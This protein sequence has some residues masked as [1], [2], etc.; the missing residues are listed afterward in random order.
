MRILVAEDDEPLRDVLVRGLQE[1]GY[2]VDAVADGA[3]AV[4]YAST[5]DYEVVVLDWRMP[6]LDG[7]AALSQLRAR[8]MSVPVLMLTAKD[9]LGDRVTGLE[10]GADDYLVKPFHFDE[11]LARLRALQ[12]RRLGTKDAV[13]RCADLWFDPATRET[14]V[15]DLRLALTTTETAI[16]E[17]LLRRMPAVVTRHDIALHAWSSEGEGIG[18]N[19]I[20]VHFARLR[21]KLTGSGAHIETVRGVGYRVTAR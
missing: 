20:D 13:L 21:A 19:T 15:A 17:V 8:G 14:G 1:S 12:R 10:Q 11:L 9:Q 2:I 6:V 5:Y 4:G 3:A 16:L 7:L 18:S